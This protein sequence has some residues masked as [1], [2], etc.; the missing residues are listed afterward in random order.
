MGVNWMRQIER[1]YD[2]TRMRDTLKEALASD[3]EGLKV[4]ITTPECMLKK[5]LREKPLLAL[6]VTAGRRVVKPRFGVDEDICT[7][8]PLRDDPVDSF[9]QAELVS[10]P[11]RAKPGRR[12]SR[13]ASSRAC[14]RAASSFNEARHDPA[15][16]PSRL[17]HLPPLA[18]A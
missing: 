18:R 8:D 6:A 15:R 4:I 2:V 5:Q 9:W 7:G 14:K 12:G 13:S 11:A 16:R 1:T 10:K 17:A 3:V